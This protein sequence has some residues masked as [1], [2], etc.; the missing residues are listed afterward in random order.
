MYFGH[1][2]RR[3][4]I[5]FPLKLYC[6][7]C[8]EQPLENVDQDYHEQQQDDAHAAGIAQAVQWGALSEPGEIQLD[9]DVSDAHRRIAGRCR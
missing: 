7:G 2:E 3:R 9:R 6:F 5:A 4:R 8:S 1:S